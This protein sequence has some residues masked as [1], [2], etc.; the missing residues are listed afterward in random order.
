MNCF[1]IVVIILVA[2]FVS[3]VEICAIMLCLSKVFDQKLKAKTEATMKLWDKE[4]EVVTKMFDGYLTRIE[5]LFK[6]E[7]EP[8]K[9]IG[10]ERDEDT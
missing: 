8:I 9:K 6:K 10:F 5:K 3:L 1:E 4:I 7:E 2:G